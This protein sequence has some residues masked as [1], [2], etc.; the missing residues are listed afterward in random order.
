MYRTITQA[1]LSAALAACA[2]AQTPQTPRPAA[3]TDRAAT[4]DT[5]AIPSD[6]VPV[7]SRHSTGCKLSGDPESRD[8]PRFCG[9]RRCDP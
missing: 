4:A 1:A 7:V 3:P 8:C 2:F 9:L 5:S 6:A